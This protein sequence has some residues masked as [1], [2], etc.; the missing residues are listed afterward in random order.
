MKSVENGTDTMSAMYYE[1][2]GGM[3]GPF[4]RLHVFACRFFLWLVWINTQ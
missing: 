3:A 4:H 1:L 2:Q